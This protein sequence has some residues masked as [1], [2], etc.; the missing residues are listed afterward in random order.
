MEFQSNPLPFSKL[1]K[2]CFQCS[3]ISNNSSYPGFPYLSNNLSF[4]PQHPDKPV[5]VSRNTSVFYV[6]KSFCCQAVSAGGGLY[7]FTGSSSIFTNS[8][9][10]HF[11]HV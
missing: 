4:V 6:K 3:H 9:V 2:C 7:R 8:P 10:P 5:T 1:N 11:G